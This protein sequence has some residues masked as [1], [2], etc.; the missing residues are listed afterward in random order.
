MT[1]VGG[2]MGSVGDSWR[3]TPQLF[4]WDAGRRGANL[5]A[6]WRSDVCHEGGIGRRLKPPDGST[7]AERL[8]I[9]VRSYLRIGGV[10][11]ATRV[12]LAVG[13]ATRRRD[14]HEAAE[15]IMRS[16]SCG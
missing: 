8:Q 14:D 5:P 3:Y 10:T 2:F 1:R 9:Y 13:L 15:E 4:G 6:D 12:A 16:L 7:I 11:S